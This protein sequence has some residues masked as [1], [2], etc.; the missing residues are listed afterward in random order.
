MMV[1]IW[2]AI[3]VAGGCWESACLGSLGPFDVQIPVNATGILRGENVRIRSIHP[4]P[5]TSSKRAY[6]RIAIPSSPTLTK[7]DASIN[8]A[9]PTLEE[10]SKLH[11]LL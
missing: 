3:E 8:L 10:A 1:E 11:V 7:P 5:M 2:R 6:H 9:G 4:R